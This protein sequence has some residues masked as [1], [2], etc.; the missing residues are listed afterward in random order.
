M[1]ICSIQQSKGA[2][3]VR[4]SGDGAEEVCTYQEPSTTKDIEK[5][6]ENVILKTLSSHD[7]VCCFIVQC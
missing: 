4:V 1:A 6:H 7:E 2:G 3:G 5:D